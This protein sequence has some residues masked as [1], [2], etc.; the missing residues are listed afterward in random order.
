MKKGLLVGVLL[1]V[2]IAGVAVLV[3]LRMQGRDGIDSSSSPDSVVQYLFACMRSSDYEGLKACHTPDAWKIVAPMYDGMQVPEM[4]A[5]LKRRMA[6]IQVTIETSNLSED[7]A[8]VLAH[9]V[10]G[11]EMSD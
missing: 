6:N 11:D 3:V 1:G 9:I 10:D 5:R 8:T 7:Q 4:S 2:I